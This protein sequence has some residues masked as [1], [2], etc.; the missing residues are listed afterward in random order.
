MIGVNLNGRP[1]VWINENF[2]MNDISMEITDFITEQD[3]VYSLA[4]LIEDQLD[5]DHLSNYFNPYMGRLNFNI[6]IKVLESV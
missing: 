3:V 6:A 1:K 2:A 4:A 5:D